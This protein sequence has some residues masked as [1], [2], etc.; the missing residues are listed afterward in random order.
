[1][2]SLHATAGKL[3]SLA[4]LAAPAKRGRLSDAGQA[5]GLSLPGGVHSA[6]FMN[7]SFGVSARW[8]V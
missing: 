5:A 3:I 7:E 2:Q 1:M 6:P 4:D 8:L